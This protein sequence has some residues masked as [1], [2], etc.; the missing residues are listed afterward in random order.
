MKLNRYFKVFNVN[1]NNYKQFVFIPTLCFI[2]SN[3]DIGYKIYNIQFVFLNYIV[4]YK[5]VK[6][7][8]L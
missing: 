1:R 8:I 6:K 5:I 2:K 4:S 7:E 3:N